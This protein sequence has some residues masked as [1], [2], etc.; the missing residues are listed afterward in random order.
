MSE[1]DL[2]ETKENYRLKMDEES[3]VH[4]ETCVFLEKH[5]YD[6]QKKLEEW[7][8]KHDV[9]VAKLD[10]DL[11]VLQVSKAKDL[12]RLDELT[13]LVSKW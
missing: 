6:L 11:E 8:N 4:A 9:D 2:E 3:R 13:K 10:H 5:I 12:E 7:I 1:R